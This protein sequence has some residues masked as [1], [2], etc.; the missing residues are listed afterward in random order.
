MWA[1]H[2]QPG[3]PVCDIPSA[4]GWGHRLHLLMKQLLRDVF[5]QPQR[6]HTLPESLGLRIVEYLHPSPEPSQVQI[7]F[8]MLLHPACLEK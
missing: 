5:K 1:F 4:L 3:N 8:L 6:F 2:Y 7:S